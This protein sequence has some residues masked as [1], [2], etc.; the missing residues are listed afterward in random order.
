MI[1]REIDAGKLLQPVIEFQ[2]SKMQQPV[3]EF[4]QHRET[5]GTPAKRNAR[6][7]T[8]DEVK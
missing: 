5:H 4:E 8:V 3:A 2:N 7:K 1:C 6:N